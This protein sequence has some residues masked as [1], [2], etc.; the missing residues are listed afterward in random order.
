MSVTHSLEEAEVEFKSRLFL[1]GQCSGLEVGGTGAVLH[2]NSRSNTILPP[3][4]RAAL[5]KTVCG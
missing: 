1:C 3:F 5:T 4:S 2:G